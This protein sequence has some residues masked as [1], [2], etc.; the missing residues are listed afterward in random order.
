MFSV[1]TFGNAQLLRALNI[2]NFALVK[3]LDIEFG[4]GL[5]VVT[6]ES[7]A[8]KSILLNA[9]GLVLG[10][11]ARRAQMRPGAS[12]CE[13]SAE[14]DVADRPASLELLQ[15][16]DLFAAEDRSTCLVRR[17]A[18]E[19]RSR[20]FVNGTPATLALL[21]ALAEP[22]IDI[23]G[24]H[25][26]RQLL[27]RDAQRRMLDEFGVA[28]ETLA[29][30]AESYR[31]RAR[32]TSALDE[33]RAQAK[34]AS[35][36]ESLLRYQIDELQGI[37]ENLR[38]VA[39]MTAAH[40]R[41]SRAQELKETVG[42]AIVELEEDLLGRL[43]GLAGRLADLD[44][45]HPNARSAQELADAAHTHLDEALGE[46]RRYAQ[47]F[48]ADDS[49]LA[50][51]DQALAAI[52]EMARK[53]RVP[54]ADLGEH[55]QRLTAELD[56]L[57]AREADLEKLAQ[58]LA[59]AEARFRRAAGA[60]SEARRAAAQPFAERITATLG[61]LGLQGATLSVAFDAA[62]SAAGLESVTF[63]AATNPRHPARDLAQ[64]ASGG[65]LSRM[66]L[67]IQ[68]VAAERCRLPCLILDEAD[69]GVGGTTAD[70][71]GRVLRDLSK[72]TQV[73][74]ITHAPQIAALGDAHLKVSKT[75][76]HDTVIRA[77]EGEER[78][79]ELARMLGGRTVTDDSRAYARTLLA[80]G[81]R[82]ESR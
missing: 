22:L 64:I 73:I 76:E 72:N 14:F 27:S 79:E 35:E 43:S 65:E 29:E 36:R 9:L 81:R 5:T 63:K 17:T 78:T 41:L 38:N 20:A 69:V 31:E 60:L 25:E 24:Q 56:A 77:I 26:H 6:G 18:S 49:T 52:H 80:A 23:H 44:D 55:L 71:L 54:A 42:G 67:A 30:T 15:Q 75:S 3:E 37:G 1:R 53:H 40:K 4:P 39:E 32:L 33:R 13:V 82:G 10:A 74:A 70:V 48:E 62:E 2:R 51:L 28:P 50:E 58:A 11:R 46:L 34:E 21:Q 59:D 47:S 45:P 19:S 68:V 57:S 7:G 12:A 8:G 66:S 16:Q 61:K